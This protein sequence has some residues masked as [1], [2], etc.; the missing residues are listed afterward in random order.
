MRNSRLS[1]RAL[2]AIAEA[3]LI[4][5]QAAFGQRPGG[6]V[7]IGLLPLGSESDAYDRSLVAAFVDGLRQLGLS[8]P[9]VAIDV[10]WISGNADAAVAELIDRGADVLVPCGTAASVAAM[11]R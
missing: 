7:R 1:R 9:D 4:L 5:P 6:R 10:V 8:G 2:F 11:R 3:G